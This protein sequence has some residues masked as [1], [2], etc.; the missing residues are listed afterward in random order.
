MSR[1]DNTSTAAATDLTLS[2]DEWVSVKLNRKIGPVNQTRDAFRKIQAGKTDQELS[3]IIGQMV[4]KGMQLDMLNAALTGAAAAVANQPS[5]L[6]T[7]ASSGTMDT[8]SLVS[9]LAKFGDAAGR[10]VCWVMH[11]KPYFDLVKDQISEKITEVSGAVVRAGSP[12]TFGRPVVV[13]DSAGLVSTSG[14]GSAAVSTYKT[15]GLVAGG[16]VVENTE[17]E[18]LI[19][20]DVTG[21]ENLSV[22]LQGEFAYNLG[23]LGFKWDMANGGKNPTDSSLGT[24]SNWDAARSSWKDFAGVVVESH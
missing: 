11:S 23:L 2:Q 17:E 21:N 19:V 3:F 24:G 1:R 6:F 13:T 8:A 12:I 20:Q 22:R 4:A 10:I 7:V 15:V 18:E 14:S 5:N 9:G 16:V